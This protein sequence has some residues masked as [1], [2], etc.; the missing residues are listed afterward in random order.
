MPRRSPR[1]P[2]LGLAA[3]LLVLGALL[4]PL[5]VPLA[6]WWLSQPWPP[7]VLQLL[8]LAEHGAE[9]GSVALILLAVLVAD[10]LRRRQ[11]PWRRLV[12][13]VAATYAGG[14]ATNGLKLLV[15]R[16]RP[17]AA[18]LAADPAVWSTFGH[19]LLQVGSHSRS[20][21]MSFPSGHA[22]TAAALAAVLGW[23]WP[24]CLPLAVPLALLAS[25][26]RL[27]FSAHY[28]SDVACGAALGLLGAALLLPFR[29]VDAPV[30]TSD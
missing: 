5:D 21:L 20:A 13:I 15:P 27:V 26:Q 8:A 18:D 29:P 10:G 25:L 2:L 12:A 1:R 9:G 11:W 14:I 6:R 7:K 17:R 23:R 30:G 3:A 22:A 19:Q 28:P 4:L 16:V 24:W